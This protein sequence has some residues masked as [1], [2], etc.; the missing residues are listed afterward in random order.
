MACGSVYYGWKWM[1]GSVDSGMT[2]SDTFELPGGV[3][4]PLTR[5]LYKSYL[6]GFLFYPTALLASGALYDSMG[7]SARGLATASLA[8]S[9]NQGLYAVHLFTGG[10]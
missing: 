6:N 7:W 2:I 1:S 10:N 9:A 8:V 3:A 5:S 4:S